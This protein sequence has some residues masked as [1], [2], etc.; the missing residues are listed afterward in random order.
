VVKGQ[1]YTYDP[2]FA[3]VNHLDSHLALGVDLCKLGV[4]IVTNELGN[5]FQSQVGYESD[6]EFACC[7]IA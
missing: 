3:S 5:L 4:D 7:K 6:G 1:T 2:R